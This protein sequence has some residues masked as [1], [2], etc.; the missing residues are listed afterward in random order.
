MGRSMGG[1]RM[2]TMVIDA[3][4]P[5]LAANDAS[6]NLF[7]LWF[8]WYAGDTPQRLKDA[9]GVIGVVD[10]VGNPMANGWIQGALSLEY[11]LRYGGGESHL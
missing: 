8:S 2:E 6:L 9:I 11:E 4:L 3:F 1:T 7:D 10:G 5:L